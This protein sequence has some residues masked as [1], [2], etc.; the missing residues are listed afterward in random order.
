VFSL[1]L[2]LIELDLQG[3]KFIFYNIVFIFNKNRVLAY[4]I[5][6]MMFSNFLCSYLMSNIFYFDS[7]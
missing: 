3:L 6:L 2:Q 7:Q 1:Q 4:K 5:L